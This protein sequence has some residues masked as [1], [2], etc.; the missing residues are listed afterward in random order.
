M[1]DKPQERISQATKDAEHI[2]AKTKAGAPQVPTAEEAKA[3]DSN[4]PASAETV[5]NYE[6]MV[7][8]GANA[9]GEGQLP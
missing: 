6:E 1:A 8:K 9:K 2:D 3:A 5:K 4:G 7:E